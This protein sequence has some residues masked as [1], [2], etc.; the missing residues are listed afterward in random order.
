MI[1]PDVIVNDGLEPE[2]LVN[3]IGPKTVA[4]Y[5]DWDGNCNIDLILKYTIDSYM[6]QSLNPSNS[7]SI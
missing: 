1:I 6:V 2:D 4:Y 7:L 3:C 5:S